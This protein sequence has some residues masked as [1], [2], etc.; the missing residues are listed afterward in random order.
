[1]VIGEMNIIKNVIAKKK[2]KYQNKIS[3]YINTLTRITV[4]FY[5]NYKPGKALSCIVS[6][7]GLIIIEEITVMHL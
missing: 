1:M 5:I 6:C 2:Q 3:R 7:R 4:I